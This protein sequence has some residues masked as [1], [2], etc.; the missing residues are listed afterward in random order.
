MEENFMINIVDETITRIYRN[1]NYDFFISKCKEKLLFP[2]EINKYIKTKGHKLIDI[3]D[4][5]NPSR[6]WYCY[7][8]DFIKGEFEVTYKT[9][10]EISKISP[11]VYIQHEFEVE[12]KDPDRINPVLDGFDSQPYIKEQAIF[13]D[14][15]A[16][17]LKI[18]GYKELSYSDMNEVVGDILMPKDVNVFGPQVTVEHLLF[19]DVLD[20]SDNE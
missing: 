5:Q 11:L 4:N 18:Y 15:I 9:M 3:Y 6:R 8:N 19:N 1:K 20:L 17:T 14:K 10:I 12:N 2:E 13:H 16:S 7:F